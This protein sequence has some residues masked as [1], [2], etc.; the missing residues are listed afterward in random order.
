MDFDHVALGAADAD[1]ARDW[2]AD[3]FGA[4]PPDTGRL[5]ARQADD[6]P[7]GPLDVITLAAAMPHGRLEI[8]APAETTT[9]AST[10]PSTEAPPAPLRIWPSLCAEKRP[11]PIAW[12]LRTTDLDATRDQAAWET[13]PPVTL[14]RGGEIW[15]VAAPRDQ[16]EAGPAMPLLVARVGPTGAALLRPLGALG[17]PMA[18]GALRVKHP[19][20]EHVESL[21][22][23]VDA[24]GAAARSGFELTVRRDGSPSLEAAFRPLRLARRL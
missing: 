19:D 2:S 15:R 4:A 6:A 23:S 13:A 21:L 18:L 1:A 17:R 16:A 22:R 3:V 9:K 20:P 24:A 14:R 5:E 7:W 8:L 10:E 11:R 12:A